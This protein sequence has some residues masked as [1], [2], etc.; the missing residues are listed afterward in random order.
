MTPFAWIIL[1]SNAKIERNMQELTHTIVVKLLVAH[2]YMTSR[3][4]L[5]NFY[6]VHRRQRA[7]SILFSPLAMCVISTLLSKSVF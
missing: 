6:K 2:Y 7:S 1:G 4:V 3:I 5:I